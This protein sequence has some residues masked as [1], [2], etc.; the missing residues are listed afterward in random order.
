MK[1]AICKKK[2]VGTFLNKPIGTYVKDKKG[3]KHTVCSECQKKFAS[4]KDMLEHL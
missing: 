4:K 1:C 3:K 2:I